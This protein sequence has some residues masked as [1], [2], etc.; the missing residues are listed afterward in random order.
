MPQAVRDG[1]IVVLIISGPLVLA[2]AF[3]GLLIGILQAA[4]QVQEQTIGSALK[5]IG[6]FTLIIFAGFWM[7]QYLNQYTLRTFTTAFTVV[8]HRTQKVIPPGA[9]EDE[10]FK[11]QFEERP[12]KV[13]PPEKIETKFPEAGLPPDIPYAG[14]PSI[15][16]IPAPTSKLLPP[17]NPKIPIQT[18]MSKIPISDFQ[19]PIPIPNKKTQ[20]IENN[21][22]LQ[23]SEEEEV[24]SSWLPQ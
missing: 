5:I 7:Y 6:V 19:E 12:L 16:K 1:I 10:D 11:D 23:E 21:E 20:I 15:P 17:E 9:K 2:A 13:E 24:P 18:I 4:T 22:Q 3:I 8:P 14:K